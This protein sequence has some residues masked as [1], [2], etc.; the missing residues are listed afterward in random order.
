MDAF[1]NNF[2]DYNIYWGPEKALFNFVYTYQYSGLAEWQ[3]AR[4]AAEGI[5][6]YY[7]TV[8]RVLIGAALVV[9]WRRAIR[10]DAT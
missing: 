8:A 7:G 1:V 4:P 5:V 2:S 3:K 10:I 9:F 6:P